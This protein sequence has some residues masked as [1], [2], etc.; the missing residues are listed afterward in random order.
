MKR[1]L[2]R[3][4]YYYLATSNCLE[5]EKRYNN[6]TCIM[7]YINKNILSDKGFKA[8]ET[9]I[10]LLQPYAKELGI[11]YVENCYFFRAEI[12]KTCKTKID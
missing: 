1:E 6:K 7:E 10:A 9:G 8:I 5:E 12:Y 3:D 2:K 11:E 4:Y